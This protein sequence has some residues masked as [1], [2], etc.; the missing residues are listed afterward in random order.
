MLKYL[1]STIENTLVS[2]IL[3]GLLFAY[4]E[5]RCGRTGKRI[6]ACG[7]ILGFA[8]ACI[9]S[10][11][12][13]KTKLINTTQW[14]M[15]IF[16]ISIALFIL[17]VILDLGVFRKKAE[18]PASL[19]V[20]LISAVLAFM[21][22]FYSL[23]DQLAYPYTV[24]MSGESFFSTGFLY[25][26]I[27]MI[28]GIIVSV[29]AAFAVYAVLGR[30]D[31]VRT[32]L[33]LKLA[34][35]VIELQHVCKI[36]QVLYSKRIITSKQV[37]QLVK[38]TIN[39]SNYFIF[40]VMLAVVFIPIILWIRSFSVNE[41][42]SNPAEHRKIRAKWRSI[43]RWST[44]LLIALAFSLTSLTAIKAYANR[45][46]ELSPTE[47]CEERDGAMYI[48]FEQVE[49]GNLHRFAYTTE[50]GVDVRF[51]VIKKP[52]SSAYGIGLDACDICGET[53]YYQRGS[54]V[55]CNRCDVVMNIN[56]I[57]FKGGCNPKVID[58][59]IE[60]GYIIVPFDTL[61]EHENDFNRR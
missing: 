19:L 4:I 35:L 18:K 31:H 45:P 22:L 38:T 57:G 53:G 26:V 48:P 54:Q 36:L 30:I 23:P 59:T 14:N 46:V 11:L 20:A 58:Y 55:V 50:N 10:Y 21:N 56:T 13:N 32:G 9:M 28:A 7:V 29:V 12:K 61:I 33:L 8:A 43:R 25:K 47:E 2:G 5:K 51:I 44:T 3:L 17:F 1:V 39:H 60:N 40:A 16:Y 15:R 6:L 37:F 24:L 42:Y 34:L 49:D 27:G 52:N 41:P